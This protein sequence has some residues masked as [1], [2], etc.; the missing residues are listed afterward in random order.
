MVIPDVTDNAF[1]V[2]GLCSQADH[3][4]VLR[5]RGA[6]E[7]A[8]KLRLGYSGAWDETSALGEIT[9]S[10]SLVSKAVTTLTEPDTRIVHRL[11][12]FH[13]K[14]PGTL[15]EFAS[16][17]D[18]DTSPFALHDIALKQLIMAI[19]KDPSF[20]DQAAWYRVADSWFRW[21]GISEYWNIFRAVEASASFA[22]KA[23][24]QEIDQLH[25]RACALLPLLWSRGAKQCLGQRDL[26]GF[27]RIHEMAQKTPFAVHWDTKV[28]EIVLELESRIKEEEV[29]VA[30]LL[31]GVA[32]RE[33]M[34]ADTQAQNRELCDRAAQVSMTAMLDSVQF[35]IDLPMSPS[36]TRRWARN[37][38]AGCLH[39]IAQAYTWTGEWK[40]ASYLLHS[41]EQW[42]TPDSVVCITIETTKE[43]IRPEAQLE[44][45][46]NR[47]Q[48]TK[49]TRSPETLEQVEEIMD[50]EIRPRL[51]SVHQMVAESSPVFTQ[52]NGLAARCWYELLLR[53]DVDKDLPDAPFWDEI[54]R[55]LIF[56]KGT[57]VE[58][59]V[60]QLLQRRTRRFF[61]QAAST[62]QSVE[63]EQNTHRDH[64]NTKVEKERRT[65]EEP[66]RGWFSSW[67]GRKQ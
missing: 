45:L 12:W 18:L 43:A 64:S 62:R 15:T 32:R 8:R 38:Y 25:H 14:S 42:A 22:K 56:G 46:S 6:I 23:S 13:H 53:C 11:Y 3:S 57:P 52:A 59:D 47:C 65:A 1:R 24:D 34:D 16:K 40:L 55:V 21:V 51:T 63:K 29:T 33:S 60:L 30:T 5:A 50:S 44:R 49:Q 9:R 7:R 20:Q 17:H 66:K 48:M 67:F 37:A 61:V 41:A 26:S 39:S 28:K 54:E 58:H 36:S 31:K 2:L 10:E 19:S 35:L 4:E 27:S